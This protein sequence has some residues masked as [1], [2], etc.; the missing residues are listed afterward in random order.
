MDSWALCA[1]RCALVNVLFATL[2]RRFVHLLSQN[3]I[4]C[5]RYYFDEWF[6]WLVYSNMDSSLVNWYDPW[7]ISCPKRRFAVPKGRLLSTTVNSEIVI[8][9]ASP[10]IPRVSERRKIRYHC[11]QQMKKGPNLLSTLQSAGGKAF[12]RIWTA[13]HLFYF[14][15]S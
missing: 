9:L 10:V 7:I 13:N 4:C 3:G 12:K 2:D 15:Y 8:L 6:R 1:V 11:G 14:L 5:P